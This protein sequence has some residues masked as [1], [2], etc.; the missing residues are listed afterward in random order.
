MPIF[1]PELG[2]GEGVGVEDADALGLVVLTLEL[3]RVEAL[4]VLEVIDEVLDVEPIMFAIAVPW[5]RL[6]QVVLSWP[7]Q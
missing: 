4:D 1:A 2:E 5:P 7:Q 3:L 6:Q